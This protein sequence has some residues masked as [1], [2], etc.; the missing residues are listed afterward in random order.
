MS[1]TMKAI[2]FHDYGGPEVM[3]YEDVPRPSPKANEVLIRVHAMGVNPV[4][5]KIREGHVKARMNIPLPATPG[6]DVSGVVEATGAGVSGVGVGQPVYAMLGLLGAYADYVVAIPAFVAPKPTTMNHTEAASV[7]LAAL[8]AW[9]ALFEHGGLQ[10]GQNILVH[11]AAGGVGSFA[12]QFA[13]H[14]G[15]T[16]VGTGSTGNAD[17]VRG[18]G[19]DQ[20]IDYQTDSFDRYAGKFDVVFDLIGGET[21][22][23]SL[24]LLKNSGIHIGGVPPSAALIEKS[25]AAGLR[26]VGIQVKPNGGQLKEIGALIDSGELKTTIAATF[27]LAEAGRAHTLSKTGHTRGKIVLQNPG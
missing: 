22:M 16:V 18:L 26:T 11:A 23:R 25:V 13:H 7:P 12:V 4:D 21:S 6:G 14:A 27:P 24:A 2:R 5:W 8:T 15:A 17:Y 9:Q 19:A 1:K 20:Y 10:R 3:K